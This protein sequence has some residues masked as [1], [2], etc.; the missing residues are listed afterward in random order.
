[1]VNIELSPEERKMV[2]EA[3]HARAERVRLE[4]H[5]CAIAWGDW[6]HPDAK[7]IRNEARALDKLAERFT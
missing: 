6:N 2:A 5:N 7:K 4:A 3:L 1:M